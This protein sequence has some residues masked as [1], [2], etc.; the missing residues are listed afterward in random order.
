[1]RADLGRFFEGHLLETVNVMKT[2]YDAA[3]GAGRDVGVWIDGRELVFG[4]GA[5]QSGRGFLRMIPGEASVVIAF[6]NGS[7]LLDKQKRLRGYPGAQ[8]KMTVAHPS[9]VDI[10]VRRLIDSAYALET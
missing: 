7:Q 1:M 2:V 9:D 4:R 3:V 6:P 5:E 10:Y 8:S